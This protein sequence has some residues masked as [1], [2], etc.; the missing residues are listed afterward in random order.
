MIQPVRVFV[1]CTEAESLPMQVLAFTI[2]EHSSLPVEVVALGAFT[3]PVPQPRD[4]RNRPRTPF[5]FQRFLIPE[6]CGFAGR[7]IYLDADMQVFTD[8]A[9]LWNH[10]LEDHDLIAVRASEDGR[11]G[12]FSVMLLDCAR[13]GWRVEDIVATLDSGRCTYEQLMHEMCVARSVGRVLPPHWNSLEH[14]EAGVTCLLHYTDMNTQ[15]WVSLH[16]PLEQLW[17]DALRRAV[18]AGAIP[19]N[20][21]EQAAARGHVRPSLAAQ[22]QGEA[23][24]AELRRR[25]RGFVPPY[26]AILSGRAAA[27]VTWRAAAAA[28]GRRGLQ[29][30]REL[31]RG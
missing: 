10:P 16:N 14:Y 25:D 9:A 22:V 19:W 4:L 5:S 13:L 24:R 29:R 31:A 8:I 18:A 17:V 12:Q 2:R 15:P 27:W 6:L 23:R 26:R 7:A 20:D 11:H 1:A 21:V 30:L 28:Y 3:R